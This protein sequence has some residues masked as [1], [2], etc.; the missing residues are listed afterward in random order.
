MGTFHNCVGDGPEHWHF[1][2][3]LQEELTH[4]KDTKAG[5]L[6]FLSELFLRTSL[7]SWHWGGPANT[8]LNRSARI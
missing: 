2:A 8:A 3:T 7:R 4:S 5:L 6:D 1:L